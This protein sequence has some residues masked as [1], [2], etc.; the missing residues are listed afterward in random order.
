MGSAAPD[1]GPFR[2]A[3][4]AGVRSGFALVFL[5]AGAAAAPPG[6]CDDPLPLDPAIVTKQ[7][8][9]KSF[10]RA[11]QAGPVCAVSWKDQGGR[12]VS[13][14]VYGPKALSSMAGDAKS[15]KDLAKKYAGESPKGA[16]PI[17]GVRNGFTVF[18]PQ[19][20]NRRVIVE[21]GK[22][23]YLINV[24]GEVIP[25]DKLKPSLLP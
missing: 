14:L 21:H 18:D 13:V 19:T 3:L 16:E 1:R 5:V 8:S 12:S 15:A 6:G 23:P 22:K 10:E 17:P 20:R 4:R 25:L 11:M 24:T 2:R 9:F 7:M